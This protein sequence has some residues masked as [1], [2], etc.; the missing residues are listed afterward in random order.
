MELPKGAAG[1]I[2]LDRFGGLPAGALYCWLTYIAPPL[3]CQILLSVAWGFGIAWL[4]LAVMYS[5]SGMTGGV[6]MAIPLGFVALILLAKSAVLHG[7][8]V[9]ELTLTFF[10]LEHMFSLIGIVAVSV[11]CASGADIHHVVA[12]IL[13]RR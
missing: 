10:F 1:G 8:Q 9:G 7:G 6:A 2:R 5:K 4:L 13:M 11:M 12:D 3:T